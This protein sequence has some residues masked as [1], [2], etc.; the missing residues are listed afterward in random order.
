SALQH[1]KKHLKD[2]PALWRNTCWPPFT[3]E[4]SINVSA[5]PGKDTK[6]WIRISR[7]IDSHLDYDLSWKSLSDE[8]AISAVHLNYIFRQVTGTTI[9][10]YVNNRRLDAAKIM[11]IEGSY[12]I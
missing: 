10:R 6:L 11:L 2:K 8:F 5:M 7:Y 4:T 3:P 1:L 9:M 12:P